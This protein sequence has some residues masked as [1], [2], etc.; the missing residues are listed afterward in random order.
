[1]TQAFDQ[2]LV[3][4]TVNINGDQQIFESTATPGLDMRIHGRMFAGATMSQAEI[5]ISN[6]TRQQRN[7][8]LT[9]ATPIIPATGNRQPTFVTV[10]VGRVSWGKPFRLFEGS[11]WANS[12]T[13]APD[14]AL[15]LS[16]L[17]NSYQ[18]ST[19]QVSTEGILT[20]L[21]VIA[22]KIAAVYGWT[23]RYQVKNDR[24]IANFLYTGSGQT[25]IR[26]LEEIG[27][28]NVFLINNVLTV[29]DKGSFIGPIAPINMQN[30]MVGIPQANEWGVQVKTLIRPDI[31]LGGA[32]QLTSQTNPGVNGTWNIKQ[33]N[34]EVTNRDDPFWY[35]ILGVNTIINGGGTE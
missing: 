32:F 4:V 25:A 6:L 3:T 15:C 20:P 31:Q 8:L 18:S 24:Q 1:M 13:P 34:F 16:S 27:G 14:M 11:C 5:K 29:I 2:R 7:F 35:D 22:G 21:S 17:T 19:V 23:L 28:L 26:K 9:S 30:G 12:V 10:D 33:L